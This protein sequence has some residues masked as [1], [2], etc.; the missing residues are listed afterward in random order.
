MQEDKILLEYVK[1]K[2]E[3]LDPAKYLQ[4]SSW[5]NLCSNAQKHDLDFIKR[6][7]KSKH[8]NCK[9]LQEQV[10]RLEYEVQNLLLTLHNNAPR[11]KSQNRL[12]F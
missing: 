8:R 10:D 11:S 6:R 1:K 4:D 7:V 3:D 12:I 9:S 5:S 2:T